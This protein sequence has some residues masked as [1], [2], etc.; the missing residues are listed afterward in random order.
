MIITGATTLMKD[1]NMQSLCKGDSKSQ[2]S[3]REC[4][5]HFWTS[6]VTQMVKN[7]PANVRDVRDSWALGSTSGGG[8]GLLKSGSGG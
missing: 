8:G 3:I 2:V 5:H 6:Q 4:V 1:F 7:L